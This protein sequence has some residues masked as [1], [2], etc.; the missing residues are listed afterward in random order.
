MRLQ[1]RRLP[2]I[3][4]AWLLCQAAAV[5]SAP[6]ALWRT[7]PTIAVED[8]CCPGVAP[9]QVCPMHHTK[10]G[11]RKCVMHGACASSTAALI[12]LSGGIGLLAHVSVADAPY[13]AA[14]AI[15]ISESST[16]SRLAPPESP[17]P[18]A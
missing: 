2:W 11:Q 18:R 4:S 6:M 1:R 13:A 17:P 12:A 9:G 5:A 8:D 16:L 15:L 3:V 14:G 7:G 10:E